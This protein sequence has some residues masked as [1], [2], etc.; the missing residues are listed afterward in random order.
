MFPVLHIDL[1][2]ISDQTSQQFK[3]QRKP[4]QV[5]PSAMSYQRS[6]PASLARHLTRPGTT[7]IIPGSF[8]NRS[9]RA[10]YVGI[11]QAL[12][13]IISDM[14][15]KQALKLTRPTRVHHRSGEILPLRSV[16]GRNSRY[17]ICYRASSWVKVDRYSTHPY[18]CVTR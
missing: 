16:L 17:T 9:H 10:S 7:R 11:A 1:S 3:S 14:N 8:Q 13:F 5:R 2:L 15:G 12:R 6:L 4:R 18:Q